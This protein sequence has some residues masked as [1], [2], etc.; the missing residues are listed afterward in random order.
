MRLAGLCPLWRNRQI[1]LLQALDAKILFTIVLNCTLD[2]AAEFGVAPGGLQLAAQQVM[3]KTQVHAITIMRRRIAGFSFGK[4][5]TIIRYGNVA[6]AL[7]ER[8]SR[9]NQFTAEVVCRIEPF[10]QIAGNKIS[11]VADERLRERI[12]NIQEERYALLQNGFVDL[13]IAG[14]AKNLATHS[15]YL[16]QKIFSGR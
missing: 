16:C 2:F 4:G 9:V 5:E 14:S 1:V 10:T 12:E 15:A 3:I 8:N 13:H 7:G 11:G 6:G